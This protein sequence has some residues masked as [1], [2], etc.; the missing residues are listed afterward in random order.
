[1]DRADKAGGNG[2]E[3]L[4]REHVVT[5]DCKQTMRMISGKSGP[6]YRDIWSSKTDT[7]APMKPVE[8]EQQKL[9]LLLKTEFGKRC[10]SMFVVLIY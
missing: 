6:F 5:V 4:E 1:M 8:K 7:C 10:G 3:R 2:N 9:E